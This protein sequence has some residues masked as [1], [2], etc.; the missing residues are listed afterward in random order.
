MEATRP[1]VSSA[2]GRLV[3]VG[4][5][6]L[7]GALAAF[8]LSRSR[9][10]VVLAPPDLPSA[11]HAAAGLVNPRM[12]PHARRAPAAEA[13]RDALIE[14][15]A[16]VG[17]PGLFRQTGIVRPARDA[18]QAR[19]FAEADA[20]NWHS[21]GAARERW[22]HLA[23]P[24]GALWVPDGG[25]VAVPALTRALLDAAERQGATVQRARLT[26]W[27][28]SPHGVRVDTGSDT[29]EASW[30]VVAVGDGG[31][32]LPAVAALGLHRIKG[33]T[34]TL[35]RPASLAADGPAVA[36]A[37]YAVPGPGGV[38]VGASYEH[39]FGDVRPDAETGQRL[40]A[41]AAAA[42]PALADCAVLAQTAGVR[43]TVPEAVAPGRRPVVGP[44]AP[45][46]WVFTGLGSRGL[47][48][49][50]LLARLLPDALHRP[51]RL[52]PD[53]RPERLGRR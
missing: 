4:G 25:S 35:A 51:D 11:S 6:G 15:L 19:R 13:E 29:V 47:L 36:G 28:P 7:A 41:A 12:G 43:L 48:A 16:Q 3:V 44:I 49:A 46:V 8:W 22:P 38:V 23:S 33:Q 52:P 18:R 37:T 21:P 42:V 5:A 24:H 10:V 32:H 50:P 27:H 14:T 31:R 17:V 20:P 1:L 45:G 40:A 39:T 34:V 30:L 26:G 9:P 2:A 53:V